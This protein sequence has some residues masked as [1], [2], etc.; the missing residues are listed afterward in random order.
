MTVVAA[1]PLHVLRAYG[2]SDEP[3]PLPGGQG[4]TFRVGDAVVRLGDGAALDAWLAD[5][6][7]SV[8]EDGF[9]VPRPLAARDWRCDDGWTVDGWAAWTLV[10]GEQ[11]AV[12]ADWAL[13]V[14]VAR[15]FTTALAKVPRPA[16]LDQR[17]DVF[18]AADRIAWGELVVPGHDDAAELVAELVAQARPDHTPPQVVHSDI[19]GNL[20][21]ADGRAPAV[22]DLSPS[23]RPAGLAPAQ[24]VVDAVLWYGADA[25]LADELDG[26]DPTSLVARA[27]AFRLAVH[28]L[29]AA[30]HHDTL[31]WDPAQVQRDLARARPLVDR[32]RAGI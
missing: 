18:A 28:T 32:L 8:V 27:L 21:W 4:R 6:L 9:R 24:V 1:P 29:M 30:G 7:A 15:R 31:V 5:V 11:R 3:V 17:T 25:C 20:L 14:E 12:G 2:L 19:A 10:A 13:G 16:F 22:I 26:P 23:W